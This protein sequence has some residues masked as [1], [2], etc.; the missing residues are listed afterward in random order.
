MNFQILAIYHLSRNVTPAFYNKETKQK[1]T[2]RKNGVK[3]FDENAP[4]KE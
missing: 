1:N 3:T 4:S 2:Q